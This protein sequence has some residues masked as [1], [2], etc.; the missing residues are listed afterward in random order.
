MW[1][2]NEIAK[3]YEEFYGNT[4]SLPPFVANGTSTVI[5]GSSLETEETDSQ[6][7]NNLKPISFNPDKI[8]ASSQEEARGSFSVISVDQNTHRN[9]RSDKRS[10]KSSNYSSYKKPASV[11]QKD[12]T[13]RNWKKLYQ[14]RVSKNFETWS[15]TITFV[16]SDTKR[17]G[18]LIYLRVC[19]L[20]FL[21][22]YHFLRFL[23]RLEDFIRN[24]VSVRTIVQ[25]SRVER[26]RNKEKRYQYLLLIKNKL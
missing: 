25:D 5:A 1:I 16:I 18:S 17:L 23:G 19:L 26:V 11:S 21:H 9:K 12:S 10:K 7:S 24:A 3:A 15:G 6:D 22:V 20:F 8:Y 4:K 14:E 2:A 13:A